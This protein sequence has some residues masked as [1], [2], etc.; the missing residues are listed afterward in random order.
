MKPCCAHPEHQK[1]YVNEDGWIITGIAE[2]PETW[3]AW[4][5]D[6]WEA[7]CSHFRLRADYDKARGHRRGKRAA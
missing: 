3:E 2:K 4:E 6:E 7:H 5:A 1:P